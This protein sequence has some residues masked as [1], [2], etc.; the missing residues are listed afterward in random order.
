[1]LPTVSV[2]YEIEDRIVVIENVNFGGPDDVAPS[3][4]RGGG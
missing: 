4:L 1:M 3:C 2:L